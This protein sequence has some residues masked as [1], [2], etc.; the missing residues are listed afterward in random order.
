[1]KAMWYARRPRRGCAC[2]TAN[3]SP[4]LRCTRMARRP[5]HRP[6]R[7]WQP[8][9][10]G[11]ASV[12][13]PQA[14]PEAHEPEVDRVQRAAGH[15][16]RRVR[17]LGGRPR[18]H[19]CV[20]EG[21]CRKRRWVRRAL[22]RPHL[23][24]PPPL[25]TRTPPRPLIS[26]LAPFGRVPAVGAPRAH[27]ARPLPPSPLP[28]TA[29]EDAHR[30]ALD[31]IS[32]G[33]AARTRRTENAGFAGANGTVVGPGSGPGTMPQ[34]AGTA[35]APAAGGG[36]VGGGSGAGPNVSVGVFVDEEYRAE[37]AG[38]PRA[39]GDAVLATPAVPWRSLP[40]VAQKVKENTGAWW[41]RL[42][43]GGGGRV[44][45]CCWGGGSGSQLPVG[46][47]VGAAQGVCASTPPSKGPAHK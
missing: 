5:P 41:P 8:R 13:A 26:I 35:S 27:A 16:P 6:Q 45:G 1:M 2:P 31:R 38:R 43:G 39:P 22:P 20:P 42:Q 47:L 29:A 18:R 34:R 3:R 25:H 17:Q 30:R 28:S 37:A 33:A 21:Q 15:S 11:A 44:G 7:A 32:H 24:L 10:A 19:V 14:V 23:L 46:C 40:S 4:C 9:G 36:R 12:G